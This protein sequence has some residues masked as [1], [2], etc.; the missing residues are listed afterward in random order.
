MPSSILIYCISIV[1]RKITLLHIVPEHGEL[2]CTFATFCFICTLRSKDIVSVTSTHTGSTESRVLILNG[3]STFYC[4]CE[5]TY[6]VSCL[7]L[8]AESRVL[9]LHCYLV[10]IDNVQSHSWDCTTWPCQVLS[11]VV[12][13]LTQRNNI[14]H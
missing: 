7:N 10:S 11:L 1:M 8:S 6:F 9:L 4:P 2:M 5:K 12:I 3:K 14:L 13:F